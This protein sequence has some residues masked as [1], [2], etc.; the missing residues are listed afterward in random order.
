MTLAA[1]LLAA[2]VSTWLMIPGPPVDSHR[3]QMDPSKLA[4]ASRVDGAALSYLMRRGG[5][6]KAGVAG[7]EKKTEQRD[8]WMGVDGGDVLFG[9]FGLGGLACC[10]VAMLRCLWFGDCD[11]KLVYASVTLDRQHETQACVAPALQ[12][13]LDTPPPLPF[14]ALNNPTGTGALVIFI[15][16]AGTLYHGRLPASRGSQRADTAQF[17]SCC[18]KFGHGNGTAMSMLQTE[19]I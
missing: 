18:W 10:G 6:G 14:P 16:A 2:C 1:L 12:P 9:L 17:L 13:T 5:G 7:R 11:T 3:L 19:N 4:K 15:S 8:G